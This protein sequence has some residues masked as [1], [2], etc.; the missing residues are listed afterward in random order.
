MELSD[1]NDGFMT[2]KMNFSAATNSSKLRILF[3]I[4]NIIFQT[5]TNFRLLPFIDLA[6]M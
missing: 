5:T 1:S 6:I 4:H 3:V 2:E